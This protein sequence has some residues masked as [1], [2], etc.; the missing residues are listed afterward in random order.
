MRDVVFFVADGTMERT[1]CAFLIRRDRHLP[2]NLDTRPFLFD[3]AEDLIRI[4]RNDAGVFGSAP[5]WVRARAGKHE[6]AVVLLD[7]DYGTQHSAT[8]LRDDLTDRIRQ[9]GWPP[10]RFRVIVI[11]PEL[12]AWIW[13]QNQRVATCLGFG[14]L[15]ELTAVLNGAGYTWADAGPKLSPDRPKE[16]LEAVLRH[17]R[18]GFSSKFH[19]AIVASVTVAR[20][21]EPAFAELRQTLQT[22]FPPE[23]QP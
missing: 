9:S 8:F 7:R 1:L 19:V 10:E 12:E 23:A 14:T 15:R 16:A 18:V 5:E 11:D 4:P 6:H 13:Q 3:P 2:Y 21:V 17:R 22:W 20:C